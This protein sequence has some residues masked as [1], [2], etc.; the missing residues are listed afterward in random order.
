VTVVIEYDCGGSFG[1]G[2]DAG[3]IRLG[4]I[5][6]DVTTCIVA[7]TI[8]AQSSSFLEITVDDYSDNGIS[9]SERWGF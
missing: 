2:A 7:A 1:Q 8:R 4:D 3:N 5:G 6:S 9:G